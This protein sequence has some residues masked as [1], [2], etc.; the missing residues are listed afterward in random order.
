MSG[1]IKRVSHPFR[2]MGHVPRIAFFF[3]SGEPRHLGETMLWL[4]SA[5]G[6]TSKSQPDTHGAVGEVWVRVKDDDLASFPIGR[7]VRMTLEP[8]VL[9]ME[10][11][12]LE[13]EPDEVVA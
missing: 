7:V 2:V 13:R 12:A 10:L 11:M 8:F 6:S 3:E 5:E 1:K 4:Q 9:G